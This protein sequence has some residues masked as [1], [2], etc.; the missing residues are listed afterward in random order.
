MTVATPAARAPA[1]EKIFALQLLRA[2]A[3]TSVVIAHV[4]YDF[5]HKL[6][7]PDV[8]PWFLSV[9]NAGVDLFFVISGFVMV[10][11]SVL[12]QEN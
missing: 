11:S 8:L 5:T 6:A 12:F 1:G 9:G 7:L 10:Y 4:G 2:V 3:A